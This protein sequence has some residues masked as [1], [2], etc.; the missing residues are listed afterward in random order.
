MGGSLDYRLRL[1]QQSGT[2]LVPDDAA[3]A[4]KLQYFFD[5]SASCQP[6]ENRDLDVNGRAIRAL[7]AAKGIA[8]FDFD[9]VCDGP[10]SQNDYIEL[11]R[12]YPAI[13]VSGIPQLD[14]TRDDQARRFIALVDEFYD[15]RV[16]LILSAAVPA[17]QLYKGQR[18]R[19][20]FDRT[21]SR[22]MEMQS[23]DYLA[24]PHLA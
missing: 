19:F 11:A 2:Y 22:L 3:S 6:D 24:A 13:I 17:D 5:E 14:G 15:R 9:A 12:W 21:I 4:S 23:T 8:W 18:L 1:L 10:R 20:E 16:K 7:R